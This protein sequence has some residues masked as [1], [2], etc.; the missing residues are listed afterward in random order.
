MSIC[1]ST[2]QVNVDKTSCVIFL[3]VENIYEEKANL[4]TKPLL[5]LCINVSRSS[6]TFRKKHVLK[7]VLR[8]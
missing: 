3:S 2:I 6:I 1:K 8:S 5:M 7:V 4:H